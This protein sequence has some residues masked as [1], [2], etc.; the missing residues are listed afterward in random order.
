VEGK[1][2]YSKRATFGMIRFDEARRRKLDVI[3]LSWRKLTQDD[4][5]GMAWLKQVKIIVLNGVPLSEATMV[6]LRRLSPLEPVAPFR[7][8]RQVA[9]LDKALPVPIPAPGIRPGNLPEIPRTSVA[10]IAVPSAS[11]TLS[12]GAKAVPSRAAYDASARNSSALEGRALR[13]PV[14]DVVTS[15]R[16]PLLPQGVDSIH[17]AAAPTEV[18]STGESENLLQVIKLQSNPSRAGTFAGLSGMRQL[19]RSETMASLN[20][21][22]TDGSQPSVPLDQDNPENSLGE[23]S[24]G[25]VGRRHP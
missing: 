5:R 7:D 4:L 9:S 11:G 13:N 23:I 8:A 18:A 12:T 24:V 22:A 6:Q 16:T 20:T 15:S 25:V 17:S 14:E 19:Q 2:S 21:L 1:N 10:P 3:S